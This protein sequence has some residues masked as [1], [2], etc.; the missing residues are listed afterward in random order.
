M[1]S[2]AKF[3][4]PLVFHCDCSEKGNGQPAEAL[5]SCAAGETLF[6]WLPKLQPV[7]T[8]SEQEI[9]N[10]ALKALSLQAFLGLLSD[11]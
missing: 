3:V 11:S 1:P 4:S 9:V 5:S 2:E 7:R 6:S 8:E 10:S